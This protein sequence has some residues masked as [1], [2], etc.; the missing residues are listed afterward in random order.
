MNPSYNKT[1]INENKI[2][3]GISKIDIHICLNEVFVCIHFRHKHVLSIDYLS[4]I[5]KT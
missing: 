2:T 4:E 1:L 5:E 3:L